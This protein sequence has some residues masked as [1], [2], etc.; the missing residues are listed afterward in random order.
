VL[1]KTEDDYCI[2][3]RTFPEVKIGLQIKN[4]VPTWI[5]AFRVETSVDSENPPFL[6]WTNQPIAVFDTYLYISLDRDPWR[7]LGIDSNSLWMFEKEIAY[8]A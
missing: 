2:K 7:E 5:T 6:L 3:T 1:S 8:Y 4:T